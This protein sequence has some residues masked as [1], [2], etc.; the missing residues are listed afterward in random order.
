M[1]SEL[2]NLTKVKSHGNNVRDINIVH[3]ISGDAQTNKQTDVE[4]VKQSWGQPATH[5]AH[6]RLVKECTSYTLFSIIEGKRRKSEKFYGTELI[7]WHL[8]MT[9]VCSQL[10]LYEWQPYFWHR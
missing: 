7:A 2:P 5:L 6:G 4:N 3:V 1:P 9:F 10:L 8:I